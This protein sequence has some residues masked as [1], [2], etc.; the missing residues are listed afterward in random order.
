M[1]TRNACA[2]IGGSIVYDGIN[3]ILK[4]IF[5]DVLDRR[6][7]MAVQGNWGE[8]IYDNKQ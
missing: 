4:P 5:I 2:S 3:G 8:I 6:N 7:D 1:H